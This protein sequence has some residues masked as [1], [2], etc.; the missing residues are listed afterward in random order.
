MLQNCSRDRSVWAFLPPSSSLLSSASRRAVCRVDCWVGSQHPRSRRAARMAS[1]LET[2]LGEVAV[3]I[4]SDTEEVVVRSTV[5]RK[6]ALFIGYDGANFYGMQFNS[7]LEVRT[8]EGEIVRALV[9]SGYLL[10]SNS[11]KTG[12]MKLSR[13]A[14]TDRGVSAAFNCIALKLEFPRGTPNDLDLAIR[15]IREELPEDIR[16]LGMARARKGFNARHFCRQRSYQFLIPVS[17]LEAN[18]SM[19]D[20]SVHRLNKILQA[21]SGGAKNFINFTSLGK[22]DSRSSTRRRVLSIGCSLKSFGGFGCVIVNLLGE[23]FMYHQIRKMMTAAIL[24]YRGLVPA[25]YIEKTLTDGSTYNIV[26]SPGETLV[27]A[28]VLLSGEE[29]WVSPA[30]DAV[31]IAEKELERS[32]LDAGEYAHLLHAHMEAKER[33][34]GI[35]D[36]W[37]RKLCVWYSY[38][39]DSLQLD[40]SQASKWDAMQAEYGPSTVRSQQSILI[41]KPSRVSTRFFQCLNQFYSPLD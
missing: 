24:T 27:L 10:E 12:K 36:G 41:L 34:E 37:M 23:S 7:D 21:F 16:L 39:S 29:H 14:R 9:K 32:R 1:D 13:S 18:G 33:T 8:V 19:P 26:P 25:D 28:D 22:L 11:E 15:A 17:A 4:D 5:K 3:G 38:H 20:E 30:D 40:S 2:T 6:V 31:E 35:F